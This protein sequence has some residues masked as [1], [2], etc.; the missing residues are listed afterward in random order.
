[1]PV[2]AEYYVE[3][4]KKFEFARTSRWRTKYEVENFSNIFLIPFF[5]STDDM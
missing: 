3:A 2:Q 1:M 5:I 4:R